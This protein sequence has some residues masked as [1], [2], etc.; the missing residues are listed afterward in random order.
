MAYKRKTRDEYVLQ[1]YYSDC[2]GWEDETTE[3]KKKEILVRL[4]EYRKNQ[5][6]YEYKWRKRRVKIETEESR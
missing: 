6:N 4:K 1:A 2:F 3:D 5:P